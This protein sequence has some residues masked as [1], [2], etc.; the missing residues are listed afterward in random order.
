MSTSSGHSRLHALHSRQRSRISCRRSSPSAACGSGCDSARTRAFARP[1]VAWSSSR[2]AMYDGHMTPVSVLRQR[3]MFMQRS[4]A[5]R[6]PSGPSKRIVV[7]SGAAR[8]S[9]GSRRCSVIGPASTILPGLR[10][11]LRVEE[12][13][14][15]AHRLVDLVAEHAPVER[16]AD[17][18]VAV[19]GGVDAAV[20]QHHLGHL[21]RDLA[22]DVHAAGGAQVDERPDVQ[23][24]DRAV[25][26]EAGLEAARVEQ[27]LHLGDVLVQALGRDG[28]V[29][30]ERERPARA[31][32]RRHQQPEPRLAHV[33]HRRL[34]GRVR[35]AQ[36]VVAVAVL[37]PTPARARR[38][39]R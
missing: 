24:A 8:G 26:V 22:H 2:V 19:L 13:L 34:V 25:A 11:P 7:G 23:A 10:T 37:A 36:R 21:L 32:A 35:R 1:R 4:A 14:D 28:G 30:D 17:E 29:L 3:P 18:A 20:A 39:A 27:R 6:I 33:E 16:A 15:L 31:A 38:G 5:V 9:A 12:A